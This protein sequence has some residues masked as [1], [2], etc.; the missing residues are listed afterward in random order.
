MCQALG[1]SPS[2]KYQR[3]GGPGPEDLAAVLRAHTGGSAD[4]ERFCSLR[5]VPPRR[6]IVTHT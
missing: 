1:V 6:A 5:T 4:V 3:D 2:L